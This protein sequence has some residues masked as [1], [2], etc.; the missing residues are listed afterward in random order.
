MS[1]EAEETPFGRRGA[2]QCRHIQFAAPRL[3]I[4]LKDHLPR[5]DRHVSFLGRIARGY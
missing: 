5:P 3:M 2:R 4:G 1:L